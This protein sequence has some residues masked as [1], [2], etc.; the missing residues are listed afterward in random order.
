MR[1]ESILFWENQEINVL[2]CTDILGRDIDTKVDWVINV[3]FPENAQWYLYRVGQT[4]HA[5]EPEQVMTFYTIY[6][7]DLANAVQDVAESG[8]TFYNC[9][10]RKRYFRYQQHLTYLLT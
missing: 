1:K 3:D 5:G 2:V 7:A 9:F 10:S 8:G 6:E 4:G